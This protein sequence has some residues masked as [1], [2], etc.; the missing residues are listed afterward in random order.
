MPEWEYDEYPSKKTR[1]M[2]EAWYQHYLR[3]GANK[4]KASELARKKTHTLPPSPFTG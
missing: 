2:W 3:K 4:Y 1:D